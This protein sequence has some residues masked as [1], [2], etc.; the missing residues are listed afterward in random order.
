MAARYKEI[1]TRG[2]MDSIRLER[3]MPGSTR[4]PFHDVAPD[5]LALPAG[6][7]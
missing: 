4:W 1:V 7:R 2:G 6:A 5:R 3:I